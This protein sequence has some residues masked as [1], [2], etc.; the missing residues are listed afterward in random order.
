MTILILAMI[1]ITAF[2]LALVYLKKKEKSEE[3]NTTPIPSKVEEVAV[4]TK[5]VVKKPV[6]TNEVVDAKKET[7][8]KKYY[9]NS[10]K[11]K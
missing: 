11:K 5:K 10:K 6:Q 8:K 7:P 3:I 1:A 4:K 9:Y 2:V